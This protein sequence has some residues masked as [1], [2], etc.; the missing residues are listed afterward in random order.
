MEAPAV[1]TVHVKSELNALKDTTIS[2]L[3]MVT[4]VV[5]SSVENNEKRLE[6]VIIV[7]YLLTPLLLFFFFFFL[8]PKAL[9]PHPI[10][11]Q[12]QISTHSGEAH[13]R[14]EN[15]ANHMLLCLC[16]TKA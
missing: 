12:D 8:L 10:P 2:S 6:M 5:Y 11:A 1:F 16:F 7:K 14:V 15:R 13:N 4:N 3:R 9:P